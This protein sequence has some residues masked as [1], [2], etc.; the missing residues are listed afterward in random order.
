MAIKVLTEK[1]ITVGKKD[2]IRIRLAG[3]AKRIAYKCKK[4]ADK[5]DN[6][7]C[8]KYNVEDYLVSAV[9]AAVIYPTVEIEE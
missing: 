1:A 4:Y 2:K 9:D 6:A 3:I 7:I 5:I 8:D